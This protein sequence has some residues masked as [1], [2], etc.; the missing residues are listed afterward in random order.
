MR[1]YSLQPTIKLKTP[2]Q[3]NFGKW[4]ERKGCPK[5]SKIP[6]KSLPE[7]TDSKK[8]ISFEYSEIVR[9]IPGKGPQWNHLIKL[10]GLLLETK[11]F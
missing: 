2:P 1:Q 8:N 5:S 7:K 11:R 6:K 3:I 4:S 9:S 10:T